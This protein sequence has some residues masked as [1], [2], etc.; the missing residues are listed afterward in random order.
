MNYHIYIPTRG[1]V[2]SQLTVERLP[3]YMHGHVTLVAPKK[4]CKELRTNYSGVNVIAQPTEITTLSEK[5]EWIMCSAAKEAEHKFSFMMDDDLYFYVF[6]GE[7]H[8]VAHSDKMAQKKFWLETLPHLCEKYKCVGLGT[9]AFAPKGGV[10]ENY[11]LGFAFGMNRKS[12]RTI[13]W[14]RIRYYED[15]D[16]TLQLLKAGIRIGLSYDMAVAQR[17][18][19]AEGGLA[20]ER[21]REAAAKSL[22]KLLRLHPDVVKEKPPSKNHPDSNTRI[23]WRGAAKIGGLL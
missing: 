18:A 6:N 3:K 20:G 4:E 14:N 11:H 7:K 9:K 8:V 12:V 23:S 1:R 13:E 21:T 19:D 22:R 10:K 5:R 15:I 17:K 2:S 16:Y